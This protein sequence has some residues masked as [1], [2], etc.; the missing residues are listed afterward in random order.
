M[1]HTI[2]INTSDKFLLLPIENSAPEIKIYF[3]IDGNQIIFPLSARLALTQVDYWIPVNI[4]RFTGHK[5]SIL[6]NEI[7]EQYSSHLKITTANNFDFNY[8][9]PYRP[10]YHF[11]PYYGWANDPNGMVY[12][13]GY[14]HL[15]YQFNPF[16]TTWGNM[17]WGHAVSQDLLNWE[18][19][20]EG[21]SPD[22]RG[23]IFS[24]SAVVDVNN[25][26]GFG[27]NALIAIYTNSGEIQTQNLAF[28]LDNGKSFSKYSN[29]PVLSDSSLVDFRDPK[30]F[31]H[32]AS[33]R[34]IMSL[35]TSQAIRFYSSTD[36]KTWSK[37]SEFGQDVGA[38]DGVW[39]CPDLFPLLFED[40]VFWVLL[41]S[42]NPGG[43]NGG[44]ATQY[45]LGNFDGNK[46]TPLDLPYP[47]W[48]DYG[49]DNYAGVCWNNTLNEEILFIGWMSNWEYA[50]LVP[51]VNFKN[52]MTLPRNLR[53]FNN[54]IHLAI[55][56]YPIH[57][58]KKLRKSVTEYEL[59]N[60]TQP[61]VSYQLPKDSQ[62]CVEIELVLKLQTS[63]KFEISLSNDLGENIIYFFL[64]NE[65]RIYMDRSKSGITNFSSDFI[66]TIHAPFATQ[67]I[68]TI[69]L[70]LDK[71]S[72]E[73]FVNKGETSITSVVFPKNPYN[74]LTLKSEKRI[75]EIQ[76]L[77]AY[78]LDKD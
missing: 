38:H 75:P 26:A 53:L 21:L 33:K 22:E 69:N 43:P 58:V 36:L 63:S 27:N 10:R 51:S 6:L 52:A 17:T 68:I 15:F 76:R 23:T 62:G 42:I 24:G 59:K 1:I 60:I 56:S 16:G 14:Y 73:L 5:I 46:F 39:E 70:F 4:E 8:D 30:V 9:E 3:E 25:T 31:W 35:A 67:E 11:S 57:A 61:S 65:N 47:L 28:S 54:G 41:V 18:H 74:T 45:F 29:N 72:V 66:T 48:L 7:N 32:K 12:Y 34:W 49:K 2:D 37:L 78:T 71:A 77:I 50:N 13:E 20:P 64:I 55:A 40:R 19:L 44:S